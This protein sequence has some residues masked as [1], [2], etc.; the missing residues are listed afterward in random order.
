MR[1]LYKVAWHPR[2]GLT[3]MEKV[4]KEWGSE[5]TGAWDDEGLTFTKDT[6]GGFVERLTFTHEMLSC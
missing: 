3:G 6:Y 1:D 2:P 5:L 4:S